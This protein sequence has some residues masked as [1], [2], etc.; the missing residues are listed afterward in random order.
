MLSE[1]V[2]SLS[3]RC[4]GAFSLKPECG[5]VGLKPCASCFVLTRNAVSFYTNQRRTI[6]PTKRALW[7]IFKKKKKL[8]QRNRRRRQQHLAWINPAGHSFLFHSGSVRST[9]NRAKPIIKSTNLLDFSPQLTRHR[10]NLRHLS[11]QTATFT[12]L[13]PLNTR[14]DCSQRAL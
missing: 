4:W 2:Q 7:Y 1:F 14:N 5:E 9:N 10:L 13:N 11:A 6:K 3:S 8:P 12:V